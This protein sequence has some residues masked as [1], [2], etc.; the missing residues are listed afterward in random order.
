MVWVRPF[1]TI[2]RDVAVSML[3]GQ[4]GVMAHQ[5][6]T[7]DTNQLPDTLELALERAEGIEGV[8]L[9]PQGELAAGVHFRG[10]YK[11]DYGA[12]GI[13]D[14]TTEQGEFI[15]SQLFAK[16]PIARAVPLDVLFWDEQRGL[17]GSLRV[18]PVV[19]SVAHEVQLTPAGRLTGRVVDGQGKPVAHALVQCGIELPNFTRQTVAVCARPVRTGADG[20]FEIL[21]GV[22]GYTFD[23]DVERP[24]YVKEWKEF[25]LAA[26]ERDKEL[27]DIVL[28][29]EQP[30]R[31]LTVE[32]PPLK[33]LTPEAQ[34]TALSLSFDTL[35]QRVE[36]TRKVARNYDVVPD[37]TSRLY[38]QAM[39]NVAQS[40]QAG[41]TEWKALL[42][43]VGMNRLTGNNGAEYEKLMQQ[44]G[45]RLIEAYADRP[46]IAA[47]AD[48]VAWTQ[49]GLPEGPHRAALVFLEKSPD[50]SARGICCLL[51]AESLVDWG[52]AK[53]RPITPETISRVEPLLNRVV[54][55]FAD[56]PHA[57][58]W[59]KGT[60]GDCARGWL[61]TLKQVQQGVAVLD[62]VWKDSQGQPLRLS[63]L[64]GKVVVLDV[65][66][67]GDDAY[68]R[69]LLD[70]A[71]P[72]RVVVIQVSHQNVEKAWKALD[73]LTI[74]RRQ[75]SHEEANRFERMW[76]IRTWPGAIVLNER[77]GVE[78]DDLREKLPQVLASVLESKATGVP[79][80]NH[81]PEFP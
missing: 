80:V 22:A 17:V 19:P 38:A 41:E 62:M 72:D 75:I 31:K 10:L 68:S 64:K 56:L 78:G 51:A 77:G 57:D 40:P 79:E 27:G 61:E 15:I 1:K 25:S 2:Y 11:T 34:Y 23:I 76:N 36:A 70:Q 18:D 26:N 12:Q 49:Y 5:S 65:G 63:D 74:P 81:H 33:G 8:V 13:G 66:T 71:G 48:T 4:F 59:R 55:E 67:L 53:S 52:P 69:T 44:A 47:V 32:L 54:S 20:R 3:D 6:A 7:I 28:E 45:S 39:W 60:L 21:S 9:D 14:V 37:N 30:V 50:R 24:G 73:G 46:E 58:D 35:V 42:W 29:I 43:M 16:D